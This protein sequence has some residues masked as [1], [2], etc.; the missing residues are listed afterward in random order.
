MDTKKLGLFALAALVLVGGGFAAGRYVAPEKVV[1]TERLKVVEKEVVVR[2]VDTDKVLDAIK[3]VSQQKDVKTKKVTVKQPDGTVTTTTET[4]DKTKTDT[5]EKTKET[6][7]TKTTETVVKE[8]IVEKEVTKTVE[9]SRPSWSLSLQPGIDVAG[10]LGHGSPYN[11]LP[12][13]NFLL[14]HAVLGISV[15]HRL[16]GPLST[17]LWAN[18][19][20]AGGV[21]LRL[22][23]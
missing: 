22:E 13:D 18:T 12:S 7:K 9:R 21:T 3:N 6:D 16:L 19:S 10:A 23:F 5:Q 11:L 8:V 1:Y 20:G 15:E 17:G 2:V 4:E 14:K